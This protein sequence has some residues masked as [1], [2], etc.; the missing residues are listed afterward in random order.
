MPV[1]S[2]SWSS[3]PICGKTFSIVFFT[4]TH[5]LVTWQSW[6]FSPWMHLAFFE[7]LCNIQFWGIMWFQNTFS[8]RF[9]HF[10]NVIDP[11]TL[12]TTDQELKNAIELLKKYENGTV[13]PSTTNKNLWDAQKIKQVTITSF[14]SVVYVYERYSW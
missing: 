11:R 6:P 5:I 7:S 3:Q 8:G 2:A 1:V 10:L 9:L 4:S 13:S 12:L 14:V